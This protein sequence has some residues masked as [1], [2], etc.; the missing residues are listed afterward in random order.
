MPKFLFAY[1]T[2]TDFSPAADGP[3]HMAEWKACMAGPG[4]KAVEPGLASGRRRPWVQTGSATVA[5]PTRW[6]ATVV[7]A[8]N[9]DAAV[10]LARG[11]PHVAL[12][13]TVEV[14][15]DMELPM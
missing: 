6:Q 12:G 2:G 7:Q 9:I 14:A 15:P 13:G 11:C 4:D 8:D 3:K 5:A 1:H 10:E